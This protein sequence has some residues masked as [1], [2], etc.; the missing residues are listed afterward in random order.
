MGD[1]RLIVALCVLGA[2]LCAWL[3]HRSDHR[4]EAIAL[5]PVALV[6]G[7]AAV[8]VNP[9][10]HGRRTLLLAAL[11]ARLPLV[12]SPLHLSDD[13]WRYLW[14]GLA[15]SHGHNVFLEPPASI[16]GL[17]D[18]LRDRV[19]HPE[20]PS[21]YPPLALW[22]FRLLALAGAPIAVQLSAA[23][24]DAL[25]PLFLAETRGGAKGAWIYALH[26]LPAI[27][28]AAGGHVDVP[29][30]TLAAASL[31]A[32]QRGGRDAA[33]G[34]AAAS[35]LVK[36]MPIAWIPAIL[37]SVGWRRAA[38]W[39]LCA[40]LAGL[41]LAAPILTGD[42]SLW[43]GVR[44]YADRWEFNGA[45]YPWLY[46]HLGEAT[47]RTLLVLAAC[48]TIAAWWRVRDPVGVWQITGIV[49]LLTSPTVHPWYVLWALAPSLAA[50]QIGVA[51][52]ALP[53]MCSYAVLLAYDPATGAWRE[54]PWLWWITW[55]P[56]L[57]LLALFERPPHALRRDASP[58]AE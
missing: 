39:L 11:L 25:T 7:L 30:I 43:T 10:G 35:A 22:W 37:L 49:F 16:V 58:T 53:L 23:L 51:L 32:W 17:D 4:G 21:V 44:A 46:P 54:A 36:L 45:L 5:I 6:W 38:A 52:A 24:L 27:E 26:P 8:S 47:R 3:L 41:L 13:L 18:A 14:E 9:R 31:A 40:S 12:G 42:P 34:L 48:A 56:A 50:G 20:I 2:V 57:L 28:A 1:H 19:N 55:P 33:F 29:A 15:L